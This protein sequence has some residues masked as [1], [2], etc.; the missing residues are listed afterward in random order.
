M[1]LSLSELIRRQSLRL[2]KQIGRFLPRMW[3]DG[4]MGLFRFDQISLYELL[5]S[6]TK[7]C[8]ATNSTLSDSFMK[9]LYESA[10]IIK[11]DL[12]ILLP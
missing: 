8:N 11:N 9:T 2:K 12:V 5:N 1:E 7:H 3:K 10:V 6:L 4:G